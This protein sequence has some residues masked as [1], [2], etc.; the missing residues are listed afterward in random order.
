MIQVHQQKNNLKTMAIKWRN[1]QGNPNQDNVE[2]EVSDFN[3]MPVITRDPNGDQIVQG[4]TIN[5]LYKVLQ[6]IR[7]GY[8]QDP[9]IN[10]AA[11][12]RQSLLIT[13]ST[14]A[15]TGTLTGVTTVTNLS[16]IGAVDASSFIKDNSFQ[17]WAISTRNLLN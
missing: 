7:D 6:E 11:N 4:V 13:G 10:K 5:D 15:V 16:Q 1:Y 9:T 14:T 2:T 8:A 17:S 3:P 12:S